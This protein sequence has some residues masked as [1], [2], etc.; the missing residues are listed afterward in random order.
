ML[1]TKE[2]TLTVDTSKFRFDMEEADE[3]E[4]VLEGVVA[5]LLV[6]VD[7]AVSGAVVSNS[8]VDVGTLHILLKLTLVVIF[9]NDVN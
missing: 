2:G 1:L 5:V 9:C 4:V 7:V 6:V 3:H 8:N